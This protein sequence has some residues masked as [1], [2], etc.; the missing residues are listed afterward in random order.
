M[1]RRSH[2]DG[3]PIFWRQLRQQHLS[4]FLKATETFRE[5][6]S[7]FDGGQLSNQP[8]GW[9][10]DRDGKVTSSAITPA[11]SCACFERGDGTLQPARTIASPQWP[12]GISLGD[13]DLDGDPIW[14]RFAKPAWRSDLAQ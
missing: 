1:V 10:I 3:L 9:N 4:L 8:D 14:Q 2:N 13:I 7:Y 11:T 5:G 6:P 12:V